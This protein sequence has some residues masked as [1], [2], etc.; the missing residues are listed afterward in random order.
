[1]SRYSFGSQTVYAGHRRNDGLRP[2]SR[3]GTLCKSRIC[4]ILGLSRHLSQYIGPSAV[5]MTLAGNSHSTRRNI[6]PVLRKEILEL[7]IELRRKGLVVRDHNVGYLTFLYHIRYS[8]RL[9][10]SL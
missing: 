6:R 4:S 1:M 10:P 9:S 8:E 5:C 7:G 2:F 3:G